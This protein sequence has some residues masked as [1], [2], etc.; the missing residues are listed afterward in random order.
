MTNPCGAAPV[1]VRRN[2]PSA[3]IN[4]S[5]NNSSLMLT[6]TDQVLVARSNFEGSFRTSGVGSDTTARTMWEPLPTAPGSN[7][8]EVF[9]APLTA[10]LLVIHWIKSGWVMGCSGVTLNE[11]GCALRTVM[12]DDEGEKISMG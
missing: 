7:W 11:I 1:T 12:L 8:K 4:G 10:V 9:V 3:S 6:L 2:R 5:V